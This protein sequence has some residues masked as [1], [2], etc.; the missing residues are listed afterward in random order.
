MMAGPALSSLCCSTLLACQ[1]LCHAML[2]TP[3]S[4]CL[5]RARLTHALGA[6]MKR[7]ERALISIKPHYAFKHPDC[8]TPLPPGLRADE[9]VAVDAVVSKAHR[10]R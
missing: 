5:L 1:L 6:D 4:P 9:P 7:G 2:T 10:G 8:K 3:A